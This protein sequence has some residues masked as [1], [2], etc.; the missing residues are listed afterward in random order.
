MKTIIKI[1]IVI[2]V[3]VLLAG[4]GMVLISEGVL[5]LFY[6]PVVVEQDAVP[7]ATDAASVAIS[8]EQLL[9]E[10]P[11]AEGPEETIPQ[12]TK[13]QSTTSSRVITAKK[14]FAYDV[15]E[16]AFLSKQGDP[17]EKL[18]PA[19]ITKLLTSYVVLQYMKPEEKV[20]VGDALN[21]VQPDS[22]VAGL[23][24]GDTLTVEQLIA[25]MMLPSGNDA[26]QAV[27]VAAGRAIA[28][29]PDLDYEKAVKTFVDEMN[30][31]A[32]ALGM[33]NSHF[34]NPDGWHNENHYT[35]MNDLVLLSKKVLTDQTI[36][37][38][39]SRAK[40]SVLLSARTLEWKNTNHLLH[41]DSSSYLPN[42]IGLKTGYT[43]AAGDCLISAFFMEDRL[44]IIGVFGCERG[45]EN[46]YLDTLA[47]YNSL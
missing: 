26:A 6:D 29:K 20:V 47:V 9:E 18:Y 15:R 5:N 4:A 16:E 17:D 42:T 21:L 43:D 28:D 46:R 45:N 44:W 27:A 33:K 13:P 36:L 24:E 12:Q 37:K 32:A 30:K 8:E 22:S 10:T 25:A 3:I 1:E 19:S 31:Q 14:Y 41:S 38:Y 11:E 40:D 7:I 35:T 39:A 34:A 23:E 2:L